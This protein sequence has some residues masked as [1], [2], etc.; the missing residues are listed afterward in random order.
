MVKLNYFKQYQTLDSLIKLIFF[1]GYYLSHTNQTKQQTKQQTSKKLRALRHF[2]WPTVSHAA[3][4][5]EAGNG[6]PTLQKTPHF[7][8]P[9]CVVVQPKDAVSRVFTVAR[10]C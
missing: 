2:D 6:V 3:N 1:I 7:G 4:Q 8:T 9:V 10:T 5:I